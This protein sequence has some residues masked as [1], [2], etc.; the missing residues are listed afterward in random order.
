MYVHFFLQIELGSTNVRVGST[1]FGSRDY[2]KPGQ[3][4]EGSDQSSSNDASQSSS[5]SQ[6]V[7]KE[8][9]NTPKSS[10]SC[11]SNATETNPETVLLSRITESVKELG[12]K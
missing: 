10:Q 8:S 9:L 4:S 6:S 11:D 1:I 5:N 3:P 7:T 2:S 12:V